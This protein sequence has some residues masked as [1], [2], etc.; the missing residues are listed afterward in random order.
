MKATVVYRSLSDGMEQIVVN[1][2]NI[3]FG[4][5]DGDGFCYAHQSFDCVRELSH[6]EHCAVMAAE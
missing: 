4:G 2:H 1:G 5:R 3:Q 6:E